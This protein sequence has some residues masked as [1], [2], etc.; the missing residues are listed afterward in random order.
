MGTKRRGQGGR[1]S[2]EV[3]RIGKSKERSPMG[4]GGSGVGRKKSDGV[5][6]VECRGDR[7]RKVRAGRATREARDEGEVGRVGTEVNE[8]GVW[9]SNIKTKDLSSTPESYLYTC[10]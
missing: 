1:K 7:S 8:V 9:V 5:R 6:K 2:E 10:K 3:R 4:P